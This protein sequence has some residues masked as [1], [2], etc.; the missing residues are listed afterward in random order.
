MSRELVL[1]G[2]ILKQQDLSEADLLLTFFSS[3]AGKVRFVVKSAKKLTSKLSGR[4]QA[5]AQI[6]V[7]LVGNGSLQKVIGAEILESF[8]E[9]LNS[10][11]K[12]HVLFSM[13]ELVLRALADD[14]VNTGIFDLYTEI[15]RQL[16]TCENHQSIQLLARFYIF[17]LLSLGF[18]PRLLAGPP[19]ELPENL[20]LS[21][22]DGKFMLE[23]LA[24]SDRQI[25]AQV[26]ELYQEILKNNSNPQTDNLVYSELTRL[27]S[28]FTGY[29]IERELKSAQFFG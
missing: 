22:S 27:L 7:A 19:T 17:G 15:L 11:E 12:I 5:T 1:T 23:S 18:S 24:T 8:P 13:Q 16:N 25:S 21:F 10:Q 3:E 4:M 14:Q 9:V 29:M 6:R 20:Y 28:D 26:Y 2:Y